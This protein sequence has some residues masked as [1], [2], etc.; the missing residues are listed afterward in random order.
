MNTQHPQFADWDAAYVLGS[1]S[2]S[3]RRLFEEH[4]AACDDCRTSIAEAAPTLGLLSR[5]PSDRAQSMLEAPVIDVGPDA[6]VRARMVERGTHD[7]RRRRRRWA[8]VLS[9]AAV[10]VVALVLATTATIAPSLRDS[11][12]IALEPLTD[13]PLTASVELS[14]VAWGTRIEMVCGYP[15][16]E[17]DDAPEDGRPYSLVIEA[18]DGTTT[19]LSTWRALPGSTAR[20]SAG[21]ALDVDE[22]AAVEIRSLTSGRVLMRAELDPPQATG[23]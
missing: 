19:E 5:V 4:L 17:D 23:G 21:T 15:E 2:P 3:D 10:L 12:A 13:I 1:L 11:Q 22:I 14:Q 6:S 16:L 7:A 18:L 8:A 9:A 20:L